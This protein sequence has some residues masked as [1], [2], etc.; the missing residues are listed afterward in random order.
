MNS[1]LIYLCDLAH[2]SQGYANEL[3]P[4]PVAC[5]K[6]WLLHYS[7]YPDRFQVEVFKHPQLLLDSLVAHPPARGAP[8]RGSRVFQL[9]M[10]PGHL[11]LHRQRN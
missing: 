9:R 2:T 4:Y 7:R 10:E 11:L 5:I 3:G 1:K 8:A 6:S